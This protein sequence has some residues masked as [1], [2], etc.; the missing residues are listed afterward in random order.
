MNKTKQASTEM[1]ETLDRQS[2]ETFL[3]ALKNM[4]AYDGS[5]N[6]E[7]AMADALVEGLSIFGEHT[8]KEIFRLARMGVTEFG[9]KVRYEG[10]IQEHV[11]AGGKYVNVYLVDFETYG[12][13]EEG[14]W[15]YTSGTPMDVPEIGLKATTKVHSSD[16]PERVAKDIDIAIERGRGESEELDEIVYEERYRVKV[17]DRP[18]E[19]WPA[20]KP[21]YQ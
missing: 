13:P 20:E 17:E 18:A 11:A 19:Y 21:H 8:S 5:K 2:Q 4:P 9:R 7:S 14:G 1:L 6:L 15:T 3:M 16:D 10:E 12:G